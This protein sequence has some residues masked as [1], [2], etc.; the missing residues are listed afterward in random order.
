MCGQS[1]RLI[2]T[3]VALQSSSARCRQPTTRS[4]T[5]QLGH[6]VEVTAAVDNQ[7]MHAW[8]ITIERQQQIVHNLH[9]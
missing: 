1:K 6:R 9:C 8:V 3:K 7:L 5:A 2:P 4:P